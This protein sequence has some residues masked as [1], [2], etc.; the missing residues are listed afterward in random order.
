MTKAVKLA[1]VYATAIMALGL[2]IFQGGAA[3][4]LGF[5]DA[6]EHMLSIGVPAL[7]IIS[8]SFLLAGFCI[9]SSSAFQALGNGMLS[10]V[11]SVVRQLVVLLPAA[12]LLSDWCLERH[13]RFWDRRREEERGDEIAMEPSA[14]AGGGGGRPSAGV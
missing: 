13:R 6:S 5:F 4:L 11:V 10:L 9:V 3:V 1:V 7:R 12:W 14:R 8:F 2:G